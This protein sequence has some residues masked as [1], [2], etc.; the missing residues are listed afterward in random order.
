[1]H[2]PLNL[3]QKILAKHLVEGCL[4]PGKEVAL[5]PDQVLTP[6]ATGTMVYLQFE[7]TGL[8]RIKTDLAVIYIDHNL[9]Q[10]GFENADDHR[11]LA[12]VAA[13]FGAYLSRAGNGICHQLHLERFTRPGGFVLGS[14]SH[15][16]TAGGAGMLGIGAGGLDVAVALAG[17][18]YFLRMPKVVKVELQGKL[19][20]WVSAKD[21][22]LEL[23]R[24]LTVKGGV[25]R[26]FEYGGPGV[27]TLSV[28]E[29]ATIANM[30]A[31]MGATSSLFPSDER[32]REFFQSIGRE[33]DWRLLEADPGANYDER[34]VINLDE[35][36]PLI[37]CPHS[38]DNVVKVREVAGMPVQQVVIGSCTNSSLED[39]AIAAEVLKGKIIPP[40]VSLVVAPGTRRVLRMMIANG[41]LDTLIAAGARLLEVGCGPCNAI[42]QSPASGSV[43]VRTVNRNYRGRSGTEDALVY[44]ASPA[45]AAATAL[46]GRITDPRELGDMPRLEIYKIYPVD[47][48]LI[49]P[50]PADGEKIEI[51]RG[52]NIKPVPRTEP[53]PD[54]LELTVMLK[55]GDNV[56][57][58]DII[59]GGA[60][61]LAL[62]SNVP[63][64]AEYTFS[65][66]D[67][68]LVGRVKDLKRPW[69][70]VGGEN[71]GQGSSRE[72]AV[73]AP[74]YLGLKAVVAKS[75]AR[76]Y[77]QNLINYGI[78]PLILVNPQDY[79]RL[80]L[81]DVFTLTDLK[82]KLLEEKG[83]ALENKNKDLKIPVSHDLSP[84]E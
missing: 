42:G 36:E 21:I 69:M 75:F 81:G 46:T 31:E 57:T 9:L 34:I 19:R 44:L 79:E 73:L 84:R 37:A 39:M 24:R 16:P 74:L 40:H 59:P 2:K 18:P 38:P 12:S 71:F 63:A 29:R 6:D 15:T 32:T 58:D 83:L 60:R 70:V 8:K 56:S 22:I 5:K 61:L 7:A 28:Y 20:P 48:D 14:D 26:I 47:D 76:I 30:G 54:E 67:P 77:R 68:G 72:H 49:V 53:L 80:D 17:A 78:L 10:V 23:L 1:M 66:L 3:T 64:M 35:L 27:A 11:Y 13:K 55:A 50:P 4:E 43:S 51:I 62:R 33:E 52:P 25:G 82:K 41:I 65:R 45:V